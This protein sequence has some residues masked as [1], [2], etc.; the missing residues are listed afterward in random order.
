MYGARRKDA[1]RGLFGGTGRLTVNG[2]TVAEG[3]I[4]NL[5]LSYNE[6]L[7]VGQDIGALVSPDY[8]AP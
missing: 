7:D 4:E 1:P 2:A 8:Q 3:R 6:T 5:V